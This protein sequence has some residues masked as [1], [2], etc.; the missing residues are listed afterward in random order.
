M[1][2][3]DS[4]LQGEVVVEVGGVGSC[5]RCSGVVTI[6]DLLEEGEEGGEFICKSE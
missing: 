6:E 3:K 2:G 5:G 4:R 1:E